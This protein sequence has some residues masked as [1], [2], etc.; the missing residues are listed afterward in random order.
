MATRLQ[1]MRRYMSNKSKNYKVD[2]DRISVS[3]DLHALYL[4]FC[5]FINTTAYQFVE[6]NLHLLLK[7]FMA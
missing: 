1:N 6:M 3:I 7:S 5:N 4:I 2:N